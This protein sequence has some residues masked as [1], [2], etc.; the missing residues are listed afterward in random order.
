MGREINH[1]LPLLVRRKRAA[2]SGIVLRLLVLTSVLN[3]E[4]VAE[5]GLALDRE[6]ERARLSDK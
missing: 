2:H 6:R 5:T 3:I 4:W 1:P